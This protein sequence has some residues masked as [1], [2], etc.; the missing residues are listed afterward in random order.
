[1]SLETI[2]AAIRKYHAHNATDQNWEGASTFTQYCK[3]NQIKTTD[4]IKEEH[5]VS[6]VDRFDLNFPSKLQGERR[7]EFMYQVLKKCINDKNAFN[8]DQF[9]AD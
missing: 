2:E 6:L 8:D 7:K 1:M 4:D 9:Q 3:E 5:I